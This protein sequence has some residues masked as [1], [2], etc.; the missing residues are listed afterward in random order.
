MSD[1]SAGKYRRR[2]GLSFF[3]KGGEEPTQ[4]QTSWLAVMGRSWPSDFSHWRGGTRMV[5]DGVRRLGWR[6]GRSWPYYF[7]HQRGRTHT[8]SDVSAGRYGKLA[9]FL[10][11]ERRRRKKG[12]GHKT[13]IMLPG[14]HPNTDGEEKRKTSLNCCM[15]GRLRVA[16]CFL[17]EGGEDMT[18]ITTTTTTVK[19]SITTTTTMT[20]TLTTM[21]MTTTTMTTLT[22]TTTTTS[23]VSFAR[24]AVLNHGNQECIFRTRGSANT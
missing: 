16:C 17:G 12:G 18:T 11:Q 13:K 15:N 14:N 20:A 10:A 4:C 1:I 22:S 6:V 21:T 7:S 24:M 5:S 19:T 9:S 8:V 3:G 2:P 23:N